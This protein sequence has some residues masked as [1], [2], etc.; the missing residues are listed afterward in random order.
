MGEEMLR[1]L[2]LLWGGGTFA[3]Y[4]LVG[5]L[6]TGVDLSLFAVA[7]GPWGWPVLVATVFSSGLAVFLSYLMNRS[8]VFRSEAPFL[9]TLAVFAATTLSITVG[10][11]SA[12][13][14]LLG[15]LTVAMG[16]S[17]EISWRTFALKLLS[18]SVGG[19]AN[20][21]AATYIFRSPARVSASP[22]SL[23]L[24]LKQ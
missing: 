5:V 23:E 22:E 13:M 11:Q 8:F 14:A 3:R 24:V 6:A 2:R 10:V 15:K 20:Y 12:V 7:S 19:L 21:A 17:P 4:V 1:A 16:W 9:K 18:I